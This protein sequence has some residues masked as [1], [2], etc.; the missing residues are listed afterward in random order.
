LRGTTGFGHGEKTDLEQGEIGLQ[1]GP[2]KGNKQE[3]QTG[4]EPPDVVEMD[5]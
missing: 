5:L 4:L 1:R 2:E 3:V